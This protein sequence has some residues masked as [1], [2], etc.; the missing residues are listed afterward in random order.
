MARIAKGERVNR[1]GA[2]SNTVGE[3]VR[4]SEAPEVREAVPTRGWPERTASHRRR[5]VLVE[6]MLGHRSR[7]RAGGRRGRHG[8]ARRRRGS[9]LAGEGAGPEARRSVR[10][11]RP[12]AW[13]WSWSSER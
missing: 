3:A 1:F 10:A 13:P 4:N 2:G 8:V 9:G 11:G 12:R 6:R 7:S 5:T